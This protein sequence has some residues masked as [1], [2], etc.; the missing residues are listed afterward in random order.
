[1]LRR[2]SGASPR[3]IVEEPGDGKCLVCGAEAREVVYYARAY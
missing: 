1:V 3:L 2:E